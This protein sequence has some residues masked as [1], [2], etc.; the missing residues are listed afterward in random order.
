[1]TIDVKGDALADKYETKTTDLTCDEA[2]EA[3]V[4]GYRVRCASLPPEAFVHYVFDGWRL[5][6][7]HDGREGSSSRW[8]PDRHHWLELWSIVPDREEPP[9]RDKWGRPV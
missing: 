3:S 8:N 1:M 7:V 2:L 6:H 4:I 5:Q 9:K